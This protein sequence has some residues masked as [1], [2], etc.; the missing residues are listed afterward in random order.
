MILRHISLACC[1]APQ[2]EAALEALVPAASCKVQ[3]LGAPYHALRCAR[4]RQPFAYIFFVCSQP[5]SSALF[6]ALRPLL[7]HDASDVATAPETGTALPRSLVLHHLFSLVG[8]VMTS[9]RVVANK[10][11]AEVRILGLRTLIAVNEK[12]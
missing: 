11:H 2:V 10:P 9:P 4:P 12:P 3:D 6:R 8:S 7:F 1:I 5:L